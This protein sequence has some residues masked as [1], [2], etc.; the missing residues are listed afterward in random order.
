VRLLGLEEG[1]DDELV[2][3]DAVPVL[4]AGEEVSGVRLARRL[5]LREAVVEV[6]GELGG[7]DGQ[8]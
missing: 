6:E 7:V 4:G 8:G 3:E 1:L 2:V 5:R